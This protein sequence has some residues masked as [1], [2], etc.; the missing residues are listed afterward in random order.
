MTAELPHDNN[1]THLFKYCLYLAVTRYVNVYDTPSPALSMTLLPL[2]DR[3][4]L[5]QN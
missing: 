4:T 2:T 1:H 5:L 3:V